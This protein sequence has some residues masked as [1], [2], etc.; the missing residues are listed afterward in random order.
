MNKLRAIIDWL[1]WF[2]VEWSH[3]I[4]A[5]VAAAAFAHPMLTPSTEANPTANAGLFA[6]VIALCTATIVLAQ[7]VNPGGLRIRRMPGILIGVG[8]LLSAYLWMTAEAGAHP[9]DPALPIVLFILFALAAVGILAM[10]VLAQGDNPH[11][12]DQ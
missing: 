6:P 5:V 3:W 4:M 10:A 11:L 7:A 8:S 9:R 2:S 1:R 12:N